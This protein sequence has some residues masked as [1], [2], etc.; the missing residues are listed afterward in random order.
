MGFIGEDDS[1]LSVAFIGNKK[2]TGRIAKKTA[3]YGQKLR[4]IS[5]IGAEVLA[6]WSFQTDFSQCSDIP[7][8]WVLY[9]TKN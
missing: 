2:P 7:A 6:A 4:Q 1:T 5:Q 3:T 8:L 9:G